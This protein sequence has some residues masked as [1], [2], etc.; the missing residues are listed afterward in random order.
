ME[1]WCKKRRGRCCRTR[2]I[3][4]T[5]QNIPTNQP[6]SSVNVPRTAQAVSSSNSINS[7]GN[8]VKSSVTKGAVELNGIKNDGESAGKVSNVNLVVLHRQQYR[9]NSITTFTEASAASGAEVFYNPHQSTVARK[10]FRKQRRHMRHLGARRRGDGGVSDAASNARAESAVFLSSDMETA[11]NSKTGDNSVAD[12]KPVELPFE[13]LVIGAEQT[14]ISSPVDTS[15]VRGPVVGSE[16]LKTSNNS[17]EKFENISGEE[18]NL[19]KS[20]SEICENFKSDVEIDGGF[21]MDAAPCEK[22]NKSEK[23]L[24]KLDKNENSHLR[25][26]E[27]CLNDVKTSSNCIEDGNRLISTK[28]IAEISEETLKKDKLVKNRLVGEKTEY[29]L[30]EKKLSLP[31]NDISCYSDDETDDVP[32]ANKKETSV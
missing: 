31:K 12:L 4:D 6:L 26:F 32:T 11:P 15:T 14:G 2:S 22:N 24:E 8:T 18:E 16:I 9:C 19:E 13:R 21:K 10:F 17:N 3:S 7:S 23:Y 27:K 28:N 20:D 30:R 25:D 29:F 5:N 1:F